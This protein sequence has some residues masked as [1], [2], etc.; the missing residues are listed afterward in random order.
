MFLRIKWEKIRDF[1]KRDCASP[2]FCTASL[3]SDENV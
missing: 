1:K 3:K 2:F